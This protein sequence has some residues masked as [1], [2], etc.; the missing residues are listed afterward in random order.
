MKQKLVADR[1]QDRNVTQTSPFLTLSILLL[2]YLH[3]LDLF[4]QL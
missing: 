4:M 2:V 1:E 3:Q